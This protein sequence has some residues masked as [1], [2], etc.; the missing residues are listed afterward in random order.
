MKGDCHITIGTVRMLQSVKQKSG[1][2]Y[3]S[4]AFSIFH[5]PGGVI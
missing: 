5:S 4:V 2:Y 1:Q 3:V